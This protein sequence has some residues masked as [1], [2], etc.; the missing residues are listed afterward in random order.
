M[1]ADIAGAA[2]DLAGAGLIRFC[3]ALLAFI[4]MGMPDAL[5]GVAWPD[6]REKYQQPL[7]TAGLLVGA[8]TLG[9]M[10]SAM[11]FGRFSRWMS[12]GVLL[13][14]STALTALGLLAY[15]FV[16]HFSLLVAIVLVAAMGGGAIDV[17]MNHYVIEHHG[18]GLMQ[19][20]HASFGI[21][22][23]LGPALMGLALASEGGWRTGY[24]VVGASLM[25]LALLFLASARVWPRLKIHE[26][27][28]SVGAMTALKSPRVMI[29]VASFAIYCGLELA[30]GV[31]A[32]TL[33]V[34]GRFVDPVKAAFWVSAYWGAFTAARIL[35]GF[36]ADRMRHWNTLVFGLG[37]TAVGVLLWIWAPSEMVGLMA[38]ALIGFGMGPIYPSMMSGTTDRVGADLQEPAVSLQISISAIGA[39]SV[40]ALAGWIA[41]QTMVL[42][43]PVTICVGLVVLICLEASQRRL[44]GV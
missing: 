5:L 11:L 7:D 10:L 27:P 12:L 33:M 1:A 42:S 32:Y 36:I 19:W 30:V 14:L 44:A 21:G 18:E 26:E 23:T 31:W 16:P 8:A 9:Y 20:L 34:E 22:V 6:V 43:I 24:W 41:D 39:G 40:T 17:A 15:L 38:L 37:L 29:A 3:L 35:F 25:G 28:S 13:T 2:Y 4:S